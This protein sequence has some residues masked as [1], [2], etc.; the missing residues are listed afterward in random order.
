MFISGSLHPLGG[1]L[2]DL[3]KIGTVI[4]ESATATKEQLFKLK[5]KIIAAL[6]I[7]GAGG[8]YGGLGSP[9]GH[10]WISVG[11]GG[12]GAAFVGVVELKKGNFIFKV[13]KGGADS[14]GTLDKGIPGED[15]YLKYAGTGNGIVA[16]FGDAASA[17]SNNC[18]NGGGKGGVLKI[19]DSAMVKSS[20]VSAN[21]N[22]GPNACNVFGKQ[23]GAAAVYKTYGEGSVRSS[24]NVACGGDGYIRIIYLGRRYVRGK[25]EEL[26]VK[27]RK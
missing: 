22:D 27:F 2:A 20:I 13:G 17:V 4:V 18:F 7:V 24:D 6:E 19:S 21:G 23:P 1:S 25:T 11:T 26:A 5:G 10:Y 15:S 14:S 3:Y 9:D 12:S 8:G 16:G